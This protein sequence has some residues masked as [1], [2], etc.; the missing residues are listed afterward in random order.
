MTNKLTNI[1]L[2]VIII[3]GL[4]VLIISLQP[5]VPPDITVSPPEVTVTSLGSVNEWYST[6]SHSVISVS[7]GVTAAGTNQV[8]AANSG[9]QYARI[10]NQGNTRVS[11]VFDSSTSTLAVGKGIVLFGSTTYPS[12]Y[13]ID[14]DNLYKGAVNCLSETA[15]NSVSVVEE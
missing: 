5:E 15:T 9:R 4:G 11:C 13:E 8:L 1:F 14:L 6:S 10:Q 7:A 2:G 12:A 3:I